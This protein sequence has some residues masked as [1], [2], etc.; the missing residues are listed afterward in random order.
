MRKGGFG[1]EVEGVDAVDVTA[2]A[3]E[4]QCTPSAIH[5]WHCSQLACCIAY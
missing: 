1:S 2:L 3:I 4:L 5:Q